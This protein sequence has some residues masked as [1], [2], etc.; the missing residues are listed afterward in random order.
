MSGKTSTQS[1]Q[2]SD[3]GLP[4]S[5]LLYAEEWA[6]DALDR[7]HYGDIKGAKTSLSY[8]DMNVI[9]LPPGSSYRDLED[10]L[11]ALRVKLYHKQSSNKQ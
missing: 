1:P 10:F 3:P 7:L 11:Q 9:N 2:W 5:G 8:A 6:I 4:I